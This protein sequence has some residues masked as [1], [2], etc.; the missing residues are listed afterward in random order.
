MS[1]YYYGIALV[2]IAACIWG[3]G[4]VC[5]QYLFNEHGVTSWWLISVRMLLG[6]IIFLGYDLLV[7]RTD[8]FAIFKE[9]TKEL[10]CFAFLGLLN[11]QLF[12]YWTIELCNAATATVLQYTAPIMIMA[13][14]VYKSRRT[15][16]GRE[17]LGIVGAL[18]GI[19]LIA[20]H[21]KL[22]SLVISPA[23]LTT[24]MISAIGYALY[25]ILP[26]N[27][28][29]KFK[30]LTVV[31]WGHILPGVFLCCLTSPWHIPGQ[32]DMNAIYA[33]VILLLGATVLTFA[34]YLSG[35]RIIGPVK[36]SLLSC[37]EP[38]SSIF[39]VVTFLDTKL[40]LLDYVG[41]FF[42]IST[43]LILSLPKK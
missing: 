37:A 13:W 15:P 28:L 20:T 6:G 8:I 17:L 7:N 39:F 42:I 26:V 4:G 2:L 16:D 14:T 32:W 30:T 43:V 21:G 29:K 33:F 3:I 19:F 12:F 9:Y 41:M 35:L 23:A 22:D 27:I 34:F 24:G 31:G 11:A 38:L 5:G 10:L 18:T 1:R 25:S 36:A 40:V